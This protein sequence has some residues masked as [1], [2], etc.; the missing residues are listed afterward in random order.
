MKWMLIIILMMGFF[1][2]AHMFGPK[3]MERFIR[4]EVVAISPWENGHCNY[5]VEPKHNFNLIVRDTCG[6]Y[7]I[8]DTLTRME[9]YVVD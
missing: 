8:G 1:K 7:E 9:T 5:M 2:C 6:K 3:T 4:D